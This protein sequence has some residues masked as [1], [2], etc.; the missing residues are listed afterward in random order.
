[1]VETLAA[2]EDSWK[3]AQGDDF[4]SRMT[5]RSLEALASQRADLNEVLADLKKPLQESL[6][7]HLN[8]AGVKGH[9]TDT[10]SLGT[11]MVQVSEAVKQIAKS[12]SGRSRWTHNLI[13]VAPAPG[14]VRLHFEVPPLHSTQANLFDTQVASF[15]A[16]ALRS[17][18]NLLVQAEGNA[19]SLEAAT[20]SLAAPARIAMRHIAKT[21]VDSH[22]KFDGRLE[23]RGRPTV[24]LALS[25]AGAQRLFRAAS[26]TNSQVFPVTF[27]GECDGWTWST[28]TMRFLPQGA[29]PFTAAVP[30]ALQTEVAKFVASPGTNV[31]AH[32]QATY[33]TATGSNRRIRT[34]YALVS[35]SQI[36]T[37]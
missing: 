32:F 34:S 12:I 35:I 22:W 21:V 17:M 30:P 10:A 37:G 16:Q 3:S 26:E 15:D 13:S 24:E 19:E 4:A 25:E 27:T 29:R 20:Q 11:F 31:E 23:A 6:D 2:F 14:S 28:G 36:A 18:A 9:A 33:L 7:L 5:R 1:M 8:G